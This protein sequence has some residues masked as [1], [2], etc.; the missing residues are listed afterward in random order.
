[1]TVLYLEVS[2]FLREADKKGFELPLAR[3]F[4][5]FCAAGEPVAVERRHGPVPSF[6]R[7]LMAS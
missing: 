1:M 6:W 2:Y 7:Q 3:A 4:Y 5:E